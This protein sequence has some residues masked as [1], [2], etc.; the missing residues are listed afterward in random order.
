MFPPL[1]ILLEYWIEH[2]SF[3]LL[4]VM[5][6]IPT[7][8]FYRG[9]LGFATDCPC[10]VLCRGLTTCPLCFGPHFGNLVYND[11]RFVSWTEGK[12]LFFYIHY[13]F[14]PW[15]KYNIMVHLIIPRDDVMDIYATY[16]ILFAS[17]Y[18]KHLRGVS[19]IPHISNF[20]QHY[21]IIGGI[22]TF[23]KYKNTPITY[24]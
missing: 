20:F 14:I 10:G 13:H 3:G 19:L 7:R 12:Q 17:K 8:I 2:V 6:T 15:G 23:K 16:W 9:V 21:T 18:W 1:G 11:S 4:Y 5:F 22:K 24:S